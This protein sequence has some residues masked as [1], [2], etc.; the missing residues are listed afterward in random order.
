MDGKGEVMMPVGDGLGE[1]FCWEY[2][3]DNVVWSW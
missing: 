2:I 3:E 1:D